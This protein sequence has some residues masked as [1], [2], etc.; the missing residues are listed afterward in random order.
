MAEYTKSQLT[1]MIA[2]KLQRNF[3]RTVDDATPHH[4]FKACALVLRDIMSQRQIETSN[5]VWEDQERQVHYLSLEFLMGRS[6]EK[7]A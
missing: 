4:M 2:G 7:N 5:K 3:G 1:E 6:L